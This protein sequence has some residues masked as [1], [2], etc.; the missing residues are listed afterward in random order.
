MRYASPFCRLFCR[1][2]SCAPASLCSV[3]GVGAPTRTA[4]YT[5][6]QAGCLAG[7]TLHCVRKNPR[8]FG[9]SVRVS[10]T[11]WARSVLPSVTASRSAARRGLSSLWDSLWSSDLRPG[12]IHGLDE[13]RSP[14]EKLAR[15][16]ARALCL[17]VV[18]RQVAPKGRVPACPQR[19]QE[20]LNG[21]NGELTTCS[22]ITC[23]RKPAEA[24]QMPWAPDGQGAEACTAGRWSRPGRQCGE[25][26]DGCAGEHLTV[27][28][29]AASR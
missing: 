22:C 18:T 14:N 21:Q 27:A 13:R 7:K 16:R 23:R 19:R 1:D 6:A 8:S 9:R 26:G 11:R 2:H 24:L 17:S 15:R 29:Q 10:P 25:G 4:H 3:F 20:P 28:G 12:G 5:V